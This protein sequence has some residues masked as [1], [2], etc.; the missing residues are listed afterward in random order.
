MSGEKPTHS[1]KL[2]KIIA[3]DLKEFY[4]ELSEDV[5]F[6]IQG[7][8]RIGSPFYNALSQLNICVAILKEY[9]T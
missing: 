4:K 7:K 8:I 1:Q 2:K 9:E 5:A 6:S 3:N